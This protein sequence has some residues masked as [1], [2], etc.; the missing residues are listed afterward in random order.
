MVMNDQTY[1]LAETIPGPSTNRLLNAAKRNNII[2]LAG[3]AEKGESGAIYNTH[4]VV[5]PKGLLGK[6]RKI[7]IFGSEYAYYRGGSEYPVFQSPKCNFGVQ[8]CYDAEFPEV[9]RILTLN[10]AEVIFTCFS[11]NT[12]SL[13]ARNRRKWRNKQELHDVM[14]AR[15]K[16]YMTFMPSRAVDNGAFVVISNQFGIS[17]HRYYTG[18]CMVLDP[19]GEVIG[20]CLNPK[21]DLLV[22]K[23]K[24][25]TLDKRRADVDY[26]FKCRRPDTYLS[27]AAN[28]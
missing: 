3:I 17:D 22:V 27:L 23:L 28:V 7:H 26:T 25:E 16:E 14:R 20:E 1:Y 11:W 24:K 21:E 4:V 18:V 2:A 8:I 12:S 19:F 15:R 13:W 9:S 10:G 6:Y 5:G